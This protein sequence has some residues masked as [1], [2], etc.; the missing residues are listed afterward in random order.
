MLFNRYTTFL[1]ATAAAVLLSACASTGGNSDTEDLP[2]P[3]SGHWQIQ[4][5]D[6]TGQT[7]TFN[8]CMDKETFYKTRQ[9]QKARRDV[10]QCQTSSTKDSNGW[11]FNSN[12]KVGQTEQRVETSRKITG[13]FQTSFHVL[14]VTKQQMPDNSV[15]ETTRNIKGQYLGACPAGM[16]PGDRQ[17]EDGSKIN[18]YDITGL[19][20]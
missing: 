4:S 17:F 5:T 16:N 7:I 6:Q 3:Q 2:R 19:N 10:Q 15:V 9:L 13:D 20:H 8:D 11:Q 12:C 14:S 1:T 18:F